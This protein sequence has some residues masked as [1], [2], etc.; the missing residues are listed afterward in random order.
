MNPINEA[1][2]ALMISL[3]TQFGADNNM[4]IDQDELWCLSQNIYFEAR[5]DARTT[6]SSRRGLEVKIRLALAFAKLL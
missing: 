4:R 2:L 1:A 3:M 5:A 6:T